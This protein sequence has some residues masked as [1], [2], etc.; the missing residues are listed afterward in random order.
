MKKRHTDTADASVTITLRFVADDDTSLSRAVMQS[1]AA[2][3]AARIDGMLCYL[4]ISSISEAG[5]AHGVETPG[6][7][8]ASVTLLAGAHT[9]YRRKPGDA[10]LH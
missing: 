6:H 7:Y 10:G 8:E 5:T 4:A 3:A 1:A 2:R 9:L